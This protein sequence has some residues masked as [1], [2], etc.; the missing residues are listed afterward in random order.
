MPE[1]T[2]VLASG[3]EGRNALREFSKSAKINVIATKSAHNKFSQLSEKQYRIMEKSDLAY[4]FQGEI[5]ENEGIKP[6]IKD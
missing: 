2:V 4:S 3:S 5:T 1:Y 6:Y